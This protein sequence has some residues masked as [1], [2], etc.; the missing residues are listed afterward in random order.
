[1]RQGSQPSH[2]LD[3]LCLDNQKKSFLGDFC[4]NCRISLCDRGVNSVTAE[5]LCE[6]RG[7]EEGPRQEDALGLRAASQRCVPGGRKDGRGL[8]PRAMLLRRM[9]SP[10][11][12]LRGR[13]PVEADVTGVTAAEGDASGR[14]IPSLLPRTI[15]STHAGS[16]QHASGSTH[17]G[18]RAT[19]SGDKRR[20]LTQSPNN[21]EP[22]PQGAGL[23][24]L[25]D[26]RAS[27]VT[28]RLSEGVTRYHPLTDSVTQAV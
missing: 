9:S 14:R 19:A 15:R 23:G 22:P 16:G 27:T 26:Q 12:G 18:L 11:D 21:E 4:K 2:T 8:S 3:S 5:T 7:Q 25:T 13:A 1:M 10:G 6:D 17:P 20:V 24:L 28:C